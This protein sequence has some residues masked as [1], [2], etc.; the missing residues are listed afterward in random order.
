MAR[1]AQRTAGARLPAVS[2]DAGLYTRVAA[3]TPV[4]ARRMVETFL[5]ELPIY[6]LLP[7]AQLDTEITRI[8]EEN[9]KVFFATLAEDRGPSD[10]KLR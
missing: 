6:R 3:R 8:C 1:T 9:L 5:D 2:E 10:D 7:R 4:L